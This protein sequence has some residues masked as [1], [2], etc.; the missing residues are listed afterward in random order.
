M[1]RNLYRV[2]REARHLG[3]LIVP[4]GRLACLAR[5]EGDAGRILR[6]NLAAPCEKV[7][8]AVCKEI[9]HFRR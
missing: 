1:D 2:L 8:A 4:D 5:A 7:S 9:G 3:Y 6:V